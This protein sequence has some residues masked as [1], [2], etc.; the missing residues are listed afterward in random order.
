MGYDIPAD[1][2]NSLPIGRP[3]GKDPAL[4]AGFGPWAPIGGMHPGSKDMAD[5]VGSTTDEAL[6]LLGLAAAQRLAHKTAVDAGWYRDPATGRPK[7]RN[8]G[9][10]IALMHSELSEAL[11]A[12]RKDLMDDKLPHRHGVEVEMADLLIRVFDFAEVKGFDLAR[13]VLEKNQFNRTRADHKL[14]NRGKPGGVKY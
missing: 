4:G 8:V 5:T 7:E 1:H 11:E 6:V 3:I 2:H 12:D 13:T 9:E 14:S 10:M